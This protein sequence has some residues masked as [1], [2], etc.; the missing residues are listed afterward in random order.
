MDILNEGKMGMKFTVLQGKTLFFIFTIALLCSSYAR[1]AGWS[2]LALEQRRAGKVQSLVFDEIV[3]QRCGLRSST[4]ELLPIFGYTKALRTN[5]VLTPERP[6]LLST[7]K[8]SL[9][10]VSWSPQQLP[11]GGSIVAYSLLGYEYLRQD[12]GVGMSAAFIDTRQFLSG[13]YVLRLETRDGQS[14]GYA[15]L[16]VEHPVEVQRRN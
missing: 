6:L 15:R 10:R 8:N 3:L 12:V 5:R 14:L 9:V 1:A 4:S 7:S 11:S 13:I 16:V 2:L